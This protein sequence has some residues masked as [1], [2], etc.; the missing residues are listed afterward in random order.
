MVT[1][2]VSTLSLAYKLQFYTHLSFSCIK[3]P[4][5]LHM[6]YV[7]IM[8]GVWSAHTWSQRTTFR[9]WFFLSTMWALGIE[10]SQAQWAVTN[11]LPVLYL[12]TDTHTKHN[13]FL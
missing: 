9:N 12:R 8:R 4:L 3:D 13:I 2:Y 11:T 1:I 6:T 5:F 10:L 7:Y